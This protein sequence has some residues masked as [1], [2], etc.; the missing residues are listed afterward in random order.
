MLM[1]FIG[2][3]TSIP[4]IG[5]DICLTIIWKQKNITNNIIESFNSWDAKYRSLPIVILLE[6]QVEA[7]G[8]VL[9]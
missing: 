3:I 6:N 2:W 5:I 9:W 7:N 4:S 8:Y 1:F